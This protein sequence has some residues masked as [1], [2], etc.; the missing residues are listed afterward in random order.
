MSGRDD[1]GSTGG[2]RRLL[3]PRATARLAVSMAG[4]PLSVLRRGAGLVADLGAVGLGTS[5]V[6][7]HRADE[8][9]A[10]PGWLTDPMRRRAMQT[11]LVTA[12]AL[13][14]LLDDA[15]AR[16]D[17]AGACT[18]GLGADDEARM[19]EI[20]TIVSD[21]ICPA[22]P[23][24]APAPAPPP[25]VDAPV[26]TPPDPAG[27]STPFDTG[28]RRHDVAGPVPGRDIAATPGAVVLRTPMCEL[29]QYLPQTDQVHDVAVLVVPPL[30]HRYYLA[31]LAPRHSLVEHLVRSRHQVFALSWPDPGPAERGRDLDAYV[32]A[33]LDAVDACTRITRRPRIAL[34]GVRTGGLLA[35]AVQ[36]HLTAIGSDDRIAASVYLATVLDQSAALP[37]FRLD[38]G[39]TR[40][41]TDLAARD[42]VLEGPVAARSWT[43]RNGGEQVRP[44]EVT[45]ACA[46]GQISESAR[47]ALQHWSADLLRM[48][49][50]LHADLVALASADADHP[51]TTVLGTPVEPRLLT[52]DAYL[53]AAADDPVQRWTAGYR[54]AELLGGPCRMVLA[55]GD[56]AGA[57]LVPPDRASAASFRVGTE[58]VTTGAYSGPDD[59]LERSRERPGSWWDDLTE[60]LGARSGTLRDAPPEL[61]GR[62]LHPLFPAPGTYLTR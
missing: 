51:G 22:R 62:R 3:A 7:P 19:R 46:H 16:D 36:S 5:T 42:G 37:G 30:V 48:P 53:V 38:P 13:A 59:W 11:Y 2:L 12:G 34:L 20:L 1:T 32:A 56:Q 27:P 18:P 52:R 39:A 44:Y 45:P 26:F 47:G 31:D 4:R 41:A 15:T 6:A 8:R 43:W 17:G 58:P 49:A 25:A 35:A 29:L 61:G 50:A 23:A 33:V 21:L 9:F 54:T 55:G 60:W 28:T 57:L 40:A 14:G 10:E 24:E